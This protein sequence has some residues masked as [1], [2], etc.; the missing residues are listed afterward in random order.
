MAGDL[1]FKYCTV[2]TLK[3]LLERLPDDWLCTTMNLGQT[4]GITVF[5]YAPEWKSQGHISLLNE[6]YEDFSCDGED[7][8]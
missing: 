2:S 8:E 1:D 3:A 6:E 4:G 7:T 5:Q